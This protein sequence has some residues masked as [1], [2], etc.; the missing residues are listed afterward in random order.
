M[1]E[2]DST[3]ARQARNRVRGQVFLLPGQWYFGTRGELVRTLLGSCVGI[4]LWNPARNSGGMCHFLLPQRLRRA[5]DALDGRYGDEALELLVREIDKTGARPRDFEAQLYGGADTLPDEVQVKF[6]VGE[7]NVEKA[8]S[9]LDKYGFQLGAVDV[10]GNEPRSVA[11]DL[12]NG[13]VS[14]R[15]GAPHSGKASA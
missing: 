13:G 8:W 14:L 15:R 7:R 4:T 5:G 10:G 11:L 9:L 6:A 1:L 2:F 3:P 12:I